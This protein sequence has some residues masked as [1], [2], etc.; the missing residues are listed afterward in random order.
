[1]LCENCGKN[2]AQKFIRKVNGKEVTV[3][4]CPAC[5]RALYPEKE[6]DFFTAFL[7][8]GGAPAA[9]TCPPCG[10]PLAG[11]PPTRLLGWAQWYSPFREELIQTVR[12]MHNMQG[13]VRHAGKHPEASA[14]DKYDLARD[15]AARREALIERL[16]AAMRTG[17]YA[18]AKK[19]QSELKMLN[20]KTAREDG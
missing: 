2:P 12:S 14:E 19:L 5:Y 15:Y 13:E 18:A 11:F 17:D 7:G 6:K 20:S 1:M 10:P 4:L 16:E 9:K 3:E 8:S